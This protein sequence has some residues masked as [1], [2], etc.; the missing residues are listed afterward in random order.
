MHAV[1]KLFVSLCLG[2]MLA[3]CTSPTSP[4]DAS[5]GS[6]DATDVT[7]VTDTGSHDTGRD[8]S[9][10]V[11]QDVAPTACTPNTTCSDCGATDGCGWCATSNSCL[12]GTADSSND[13]ACTGV[14]WIWDP[15]YCPGQGDL[16]ATHSASCDDCAMQPGCG[17]CPGMG[18]RAGTADGPLV[19]GAVTTCDGWAYQT[20]DC[21][22]IDAGTDAGTD[23]STPDAST[24]AGV[25]DA[26]TDASGG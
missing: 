3:H 20:T 15:A 1:S 5:D 4:G 17:F 16:C 10:D 26:S 14:S 11:A 9:Q 8:V 18:C 7:M 21:T 6:A 13:G 12:D 25:A 2:A 19:G 22:A 24:D 23:A